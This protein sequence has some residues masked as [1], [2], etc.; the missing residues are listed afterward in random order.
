MD[1]IIL[2][3][4]EDDND[5]F[6]D[7]DQHPS[8]FKHPFNLIIVRI[9]GSGKTT[10]LNILIKYYLNFNAL[11]VCAKTIN[12][13]KYS[14]LREREILCLKMLKEMIFSKLLKL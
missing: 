9:T 6:R 12:E 3:D 7:P 8:M 2:Q 10:L 11:Y 14:Q 1:P 5:D 13:S 4:S